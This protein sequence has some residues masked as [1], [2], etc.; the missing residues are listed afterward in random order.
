MTGAGQGSPSDV[1]GRGSQHMGTVVRE[2]VQGA[3]TLKVEN[4]VRL[5]Q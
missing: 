5:A 2:G 3:G 1:G 4:K